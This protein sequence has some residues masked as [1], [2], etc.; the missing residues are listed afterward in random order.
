[1]LTDV[2]MLWFY[3]WT[4][5]LRPFHY[6]HVSS[7]SFAILRRRCPII[8]S[9]TKWIDSGKEKRTPTIIDCQTSVSV[10]LEKRW[11]GLHIS[12]VKLSWDQKW[13]TVDS[14]H[15]ELAVN[16]NPR[17]LCR[18]IKANQSCFQTLMTVSW[19]IKTH[20]LQHIRAIYWLLRF[21]KTLQ[22]FKKIY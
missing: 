11:R 9:R 21:M 6:Q 7:V 1:M 2:V 15:S 4:A 16:W 17:C 5:S 13:A 14:S 3:E 22:M 12:W 19:L 18:L 20:Q 10:P 8:Q